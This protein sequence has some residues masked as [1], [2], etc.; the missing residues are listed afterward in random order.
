[1]FTLHF[2]LVLLIT[3][4]VVMLI[5]QFL[6]ICN[7]ELFLKKTMFSSGVMLQS[8]KNIFFF[9]SHCPYNCFSTRILIQISVQLYEQLKPMSTSHCKFRKPT[10]PLEN[11]NFLWYLNFWIYVFLLLPYHYYLNPPLSIVSLIHLLINYV[12]IVLTV[13][14][15]LKTSGR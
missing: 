12:L 2:I 14:C 7:F 1:M 4:F 6:C 11:L 9:C 8:F 10:N 3:K 15:S 13:L 5:F